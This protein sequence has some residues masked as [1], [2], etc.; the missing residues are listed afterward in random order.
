[1]LPEKL[2]LLFPFVIFA[3]GFI[4]TL[5]LSIVP[6]GLAE[7]RLPQSITRQIKAHRGLALFCLIAGALWSVQ[8]LW[9]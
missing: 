6:D 8:N 9:L 2:D 5:A 4:M 3:Y 1:M 7:Q